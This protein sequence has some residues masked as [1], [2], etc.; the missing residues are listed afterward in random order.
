MGDA[1][2]SAVTQSGDARRF[3]AFISYSHA[4]AD[5]AAK[6]QRK[7][8]R[9]RLPKRIAEARAANSPA[10]G[11]I[12]RDREDFAAASSLSAAIREAI[13]QAEAMVVMC[14]P[15]A[16]ASPWV[17]AE[18]ELFRQLHPGRP[19]LAALLS[20]EPAASF[21]SALT[22]DGNEPLAADLRPEGDGEQLAFLKIV[23]GIA[24]VPLDELIQRDAQRRIRSVTAITVGALAAMLI[25][26]I[27]TAYAIQARNEAARQRASAEGLVEY[28]LTDLRTNLEGVGS[29]KVMDAVNARAM[30]HYRLQGNLADL[31]ADSLERRARVLHVMGEDLEK[32]GELDRALASFKEAHRVT[33]A[34]LANDPNNPDRIFAHAQSEYWVGHPAELKEDWLTALKQYRAYRALG[35]R[36]IEIAPDNP[37][38]MMEMGWGHLNIGIVEL[39]SRANTGYGQDNFENASQWMQKARLTRPNDLSIIGELGG[40]NAWLADSYFLQKNYAK[41][42]EARK[43]ELSVKLQILAKDPSNNAA[44]FDVAKA[45]Y[46]VARNLQM[47]KKPAAAE[48]YAQQSYLDM[49]KLL[50]I[51]QNNAE[52]NQVFRKLE[53]LRRTL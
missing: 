20:S 24:G 49:T 29:F 43:S 45:Q 34:L 46:A 36:L 53:Q 11:R 51:E 26:G 48:R 5:A 33:A 8:E 35:K 16:A 40:A 3:A 12:F 47:L 14:S 19:I 1:S 31:P 30:E 42:L 37:D 27:M 17:A 39:K 10:L 4:D 23:A 21:P 6:L 44:R 41:S 25:M 32:R 52:W 28:M 38:Y 2:D 13:S 15:D 9:Y 50:K 18:I 22:A 7:L